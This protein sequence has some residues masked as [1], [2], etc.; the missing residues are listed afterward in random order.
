MW[1]RCTTC[2]LQKS[3]PACY[4]YKALVYQESPQPNGPET[5][6]HFT[7][8]H[9]PQSSYTITHKI[10]PNQ[11]IT[12]G[13][14]KYTSYWNYITHSQHKVEIYLTLN[15]QYTVAEYLTTVTAKNLTKTLTVY[16]LSDHSLAVEKGRHHQTWPP[17]EDRLCCDEGAIE[18]EL[19]FLTQCHKYRNI[20][21]KFFPQFEKHCPK[22]GGLTAREKLPL[23]LEKKKECAVVAAK[24]V[25]SCHNKRDNQQDMDL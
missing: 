3:D 4:H 6:W 18:T 17:I 8:W 11:K 16:R 24:Y 12:K 22:F 25:I 7:F 15:R 19:H 1:K 10:R 20:W 21:E 5:G 2:G 13:K 23:I 9:L 14:E